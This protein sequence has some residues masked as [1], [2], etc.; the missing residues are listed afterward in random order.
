VTT[1][2]AELLLEGVH[3]RGRGADDLLD[4]GGDR[5]VARHREADQRL[6]RQVLQQR[7]RLDDEQLLLLLLEVGI[8]SSTW[9]WWDHA[10]A[11]AHHRPS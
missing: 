10:A 11:A 6:H 1:S 3:H 2:T 7:V 8:V 9:D 5:P 4:D